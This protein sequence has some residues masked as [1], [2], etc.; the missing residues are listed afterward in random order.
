MLYGPST[1]IVTAKRIL[2][3][4]YRYL[5]VRGYTDNTAR[6]INRHISGERHRNTI[7][8]LNREYRRTD[9]DDLDVF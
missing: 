3:H 8:Q 5:R 6:I 1:S 9:G 7:D 2:Y 4:V